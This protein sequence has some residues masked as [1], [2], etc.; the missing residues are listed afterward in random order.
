VYAVFAEN[1]QPQG[2]LFIQSSLFEVSSC[3]A[4]SLATIR[5]H[6]SPWPFG[7]GR[8]HI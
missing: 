2:C 8:Q 6:G 7:I 4:I 5:S 3:Q 1:A